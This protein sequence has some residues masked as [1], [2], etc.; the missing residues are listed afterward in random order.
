MTQTA[1]GTYIVECT[2]GHDIKVEA[3]DQASAVEQ[4]K[5]MMDESGIEAHFK[6]YHP[7]EPVPAVE[8]IHA[9]IETDVM[10]M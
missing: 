3:G 2:C 5:E 4:M 9:H 8:E 1:T 7:G 6:K 10:E